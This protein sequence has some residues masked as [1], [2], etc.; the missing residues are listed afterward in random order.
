MN[1]GHLR[2]EMESPG[3]FVAG[4]KSGGFGGSVWTRR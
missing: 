1:H 3:K 4:E 2:L